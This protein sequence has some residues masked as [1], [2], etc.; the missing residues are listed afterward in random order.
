MKYNTNMEK[1]SVSI[2]SSNKSHRLFVKSLFPDFIIAD[3]VCATTDAIIVVGN[4]DELDCPVRP[5]RDTQVIA[6]NVAI[7]NSKD[8]YMGKYDYFDHVFLK[9]TKYLVRLQRRLGAKFAHYLPD[10]DILTNVRPTQ[11]LQNSLLNREFG[12]NIHKYLRSLWNTKQLMGIVQG[13][14]RRT[15][16]IDVMDSTSANDVY[17]SFT[18]LQRSLTKNNTVRPSE[19]AM[20]RLISFVSLRLTGDISNDILMKTLKKTPNRF[21][22]CILALKRQHSK[23]MLKDCARLSLVHHGSPKYPWI[24]IM[25]GISSLM[26]DNGLL[27]DPCIGNTFRDSEALELDGIIPYTVS[28]VG[29]IHDLPDQL[30]ENTLFCKSLRTCNALICFTDVIYREI[31]KILEA[32]NVNGCV[33]HNVELI[34]LAHPAC[35][36]NS[37]YSSPSPQQIV[38]FPPVNKEIPFSFYR[39]RTPEMMKKV[40][41][42][43][44]LPELKIT[45]EAIQNVEEDGTL[46]QSILNHIQNEDFL[47]DTFGLQYAD[48]PYEFSFTVNSSL[49]PV[50]STDKN[51]T[52]VTRL[53]SYIEDVLDS[54]QSVSSEDYAIADSIV[55]LDEDNVAVLTQCM[56]RNIP[57]LINRSLSNVE[58]LGKDYPMFFDS[59]EHAS[60]LM[61]D[62]IINSAYVYLKN[63]DKYQNTV[64]NFI[65][66]IKEC[67]FYTSLF[68]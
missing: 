35:I 40:A 17:K 20:K 28:W 68:Q 2:I 24:D 37:F 11:E 56:M 26:T 55:F 42:G 4:D 12:K 50:Q 59:L 61:D 1:Y 66:K 31:E 9:N 47:L 33:M 7:E 36:P 65:G 41:F 3:D 13:M 6:V 32:W 67:K 23:H 58:Y 29:L 19:S 5:N 25:K 53:K 63:M 21:L 54:C 57:V 64:E 16:F 52:Y 18:K 15:P 45:K 22:D 62:K 48:V 34:K 44:N 60:S 39:L 10:L 27:F 51:G 43:C 49:G 38:I 8:I 14:E 46:L 30:S